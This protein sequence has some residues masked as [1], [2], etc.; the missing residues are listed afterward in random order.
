MLFACTHSTCISANRTENP[1]PELTELVIPIAG[2]SLLPYCHFDVPESSYPSDGRRDAKLPGPI[3]YQAAADG[4][5]PPDTRVIEFNV[6]GIG[7]TYV[8]Y[9]LFKDF[10]VTKE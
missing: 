6:V 8:R 7:E 5:L 2:R 9:A 1:D 4:S 10:Q 3:D